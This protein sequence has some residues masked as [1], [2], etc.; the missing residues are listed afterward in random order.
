MFGFTN[1]LQIP[2]PLDIDYQLLRSI[3]QRFR[4]KRHFWEKLEQILEFLE[5]CDD[6][7]L[8][9]DAEYA[10][11]ALHM[12]E[13]AKSLAGGLA[14]IESDHVFRNGKQLIGTT[15]RRRLSA[16]QRYLQGKAE[17][18]QIIAHKSQ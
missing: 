13:A 7:M 14:P 8:H 15:P 12:V 18:F 17:I 3:P 5:T 11:F 9:W 2:V 6:P 4:D 16:Q 10:R 1:P